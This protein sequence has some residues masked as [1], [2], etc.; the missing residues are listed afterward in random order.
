MDLWIYLSAYHKLSKL[1]G[2]DPLHM[3]LL[4]TTRRDGSF[5]RKNQ[6]NE[7]NAEGKKKHTMKPFYINPWD[8]DDVIQILEEDMSLT[9]SEVGELECRSNYCIRYLSSIDVNKNDLLYKIYGEQ[10]DKSP[11]FMRN[12]MRLYLMTNK[13]QLECLAQ[14]YLDSTNMKLISWMK[15]IKEGRKGNLLTLYIL[16]LVTGTH[17]C[18]HLKQQKCW[19]TLKEKPSTHAEFMQ[20]CNIHLSYMGRN[21][22]IQLILRTTK[23]SYKFFGID[24]PIEL[25][26]SVT[27]DSGTL[28]SEEMST[29][30]MI[31]DETPN[32]IVKSINS[33]DVQPKNVLLVSAE[34]HASFNDSPTRKQVI[35]EK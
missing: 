5:K 28:T 13:K 20:R 3:S 27:T 21:N 8:F 11:S 16:S 34:V 35:K 33:S 12:W 1:I 23:V 24:N 15:G 4:P 9:K 25:M 2:L 22:F 19:T 14:N 6:K 7:K 26:Q 18:I 32:P 17:C 30:D 10:V 29:L 31:M